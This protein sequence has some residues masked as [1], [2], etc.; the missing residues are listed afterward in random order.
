MTLLAVA[1][2]LQQQPAKHV[3]DT[4][5]IYTPPQNTVGTGWVPTSI[6]GLLTSIALIIAITGAGSF[7]A[8]WRWLLKPVYAKIEAVKKAI[9]DAHDIDIA[10]LKR[11]IE[12][13]ASVRE[14]GI[15]DIINRERGFLTLHKRELKT[16]VD[17]VGGRCN[18][19]DRRTEKVEERARS[20]EDRMR[21]S[22]N[23]R[24]V[25]HRELGGVQGEVRALRDEQL[26]SSTR[27]I[28]HIDMRARETMG[29]IKEN[30][31]RI[32]TLEHSVAVINDRNDRHRRGEVT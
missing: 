19:L 11:L 20:L 28:A 32:E 30:S 13:E 22:E 26:D 6:V 18:D 14:R 25:L 4:V 3:V 24:G 16:D 15:D 2:W 23:D 1:T 8:M 5:R 7:A 21:D 29:A 31:K 27:I 12:A 9:K 17:K 10:K